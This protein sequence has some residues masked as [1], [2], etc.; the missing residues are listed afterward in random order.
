MFTDLAHEIRTALRALARVPVLT[1]VIVLTVGIGIGASTAIFAAVDAALLRPLPYA[2]SGR[3]VWIYTDAPPFKWR[4]SVADFLALEAQQTHFESVAAYTDRSMAFTTG[5]TAELLNGRVVTASYFRLLGIVPALGRDFAPWDAKPGSAPVVIVSDGFWRQRL[6]SRMDIVGT[7]VR[8]DGAD[9]TVAGVLPP[10]VGPFER[11]Q[12]FFLAAQLSPPPRRGPFLY[13]VVG[14]LRDGAEPASATAELHA[15]N[16]RIFPLWK[17]SY[18]D[19]KA[20]WNMT[21][22]KARVVGDVGTIAGLSLAAVGLV[23]LI[24]C[25]NASNL[26][27][28]RVT[29]RRRELVVRAALGASRARV[30]RPLFVESALLAAAAAALGVVLARVG[31][32]VVRSVGA[33]YLPRTHDVALGGRVLA[34]LVILAA[35]SAAIFAIVPAFQGSGM[36]LDQSHRSGRSSTAGVGARRLRQ[37]LVA[38]QFAICTPLLIV[39]ALLLVSLN[40]LRQ[41]DLG[42]D[43][44]N[45]VTATVRLPSALYQREGSVAAFWAELLTRL[46]SLPGV[47]GVAFADGRPPNDVGNFNNFEL[48]ESV[49]PPSGSGQAQPV[50]PWVAVSPEYFSVLGLTLVEGR[51]LDARD[52]QRETIE[53]VVVDRAWAR[54]F[55][56]GQ[57][58][59]GKRF[60]EGGCTQCPWTTVVGVVSEV[61]YAGLEQPD[62]GTVYWALG[63][64]TSRVAVLRTQGT[65]SAVLPGVRSVVSGLD[66]NVVLTDVA[67]IDQLVAESLD[68]SRSLSLLVAS[69]A[70]IALLLSVVGIYGVMAFYVEQH[71]RDIS[72]RMALG[73]R[74][75]NVIQLVVGR[76]LAVVAAGIGLGLI[77]AFAST[78][79][80]ATL[81]FGVDPVSVPTF[82]AAA[83]GLFLTALAACLIPAVRATR[84]EPGVLLRD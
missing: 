32:D 7:A 31:V 29:S 48:E 69:L 49:T 42:F 15:I 39:A 62:Q 70:A 8:L 71:S 22:L 35:I 43:T 27:V 5:A 56:P 52:A 47:V 11:R 24:A 53:S 3:L 73:G 60:K 46:Q 51:L 61:K 16:R 17:S 57:S 30:L 34:F 26:L 58:A 77:G 74:A 10:R 33:T 75:R 80:M 82:A 40:A 9:Y 65:P 50:T 37:G 83:L 41:V 66:A 68:S 28:A 44:R 2:D 54:R 20:T 36:R 64:D 81:L 25:V 6:G 78:R 67:T 14:R 76:G 45:V 72:I 79:L 13:T 21:D 4:F 19:D 59:I 63:D 1:A 84:M 12:D 38:G 55:F 23:W 18:Q